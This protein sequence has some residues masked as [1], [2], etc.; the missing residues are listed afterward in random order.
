MKEIRE[1]REEEE[2]ARE[3]ELIIIDGAEIK[4]NSHLGEFKVLSDVPTTQ[5]E[6]TGTTVENQTVNFTFYDGF[7]L[8]TT[9]AWLDYG[10]MKVQENVVLIKKSFLPGAG[11]M[12]GSS[13]M[14]TGEVKF[15]NSGQ[16]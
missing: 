13:S 8:K 3:D 10:E 14:E 7:D 4:F 6:P 16:I 15:M 5:D 2:A 12:P 11:K 1:A 9:G